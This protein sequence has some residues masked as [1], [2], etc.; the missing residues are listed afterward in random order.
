[1]EAVARNAVS[2]PSVAAVAAR[3]G[4]VSA[5]SSVSVSKTA[6]FG[7]SR[8]N[9]L[10]AKIP[11]GGR[12]ANRAVVCMAKESAAAGYAAALVELGQSTSTLEAIHKDIE[13]LSGLVANN[14]LAS[15]LAS[16][17]ASDA[18]KKSVIKSL[19][20]ESGFNSYTTNFLNVLVDKKRVN[21]LK[22]IAAVFEELY[23]DITDT[24]VAIVTSAVKLENSQQALIAKKLQSMTGA[25][26]IKLKNV[27]DATLIAGFIVKY[28]KDGS[29]LIDMSVKGQ[30]DRLA[31]QFELN[32]N[33][34][35]SA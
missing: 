18:Q 7:G 13:T 16:P 15:F 33:A 31:Q 35:T 2:C 34:L 3:T 12:S 23:C 1:M 22:E 28:G 5:R 14:E 19:A 25:K 27:V 10:V 8:S 20:A 4:S 26:N 29:Q 24:Q 11:T 21:I 17:V 30:L 6:L 32:E 9:A